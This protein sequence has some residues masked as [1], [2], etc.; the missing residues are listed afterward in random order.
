VRHVTKKV[1]ARL[2]AAHS[3]RLLIVSKCFNLC[4]KKF[5][6]DTKTHIP[7]HIFSSL[8]GGSSNVDLSPD[9]MFPGFW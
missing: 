4:K 2:Y 5:N 9:W 1:I 7:F 6:I 3:L 8:R